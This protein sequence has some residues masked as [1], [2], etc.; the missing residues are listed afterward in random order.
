MNV[1]VRP[2][3]VAASVVALLVSLPLVALRAQPPARAGV[4]SSGRHPVRQGGPHGNA[5]ERPEVSRPPERRP[6][7]RVSLRLAVKAGSLDEAD[8]QQGLAHLIEH[9][10]FNGSAHFKPGEL[11]SYFESIGARLGPHV[12]AYT[13]FDETV[14]M[15]DLPTDKPEIVDEGAHRARRLRRRADARSRPKSTR[16]AASSSRNGAAASAPARASATSSSRSCSTTRAT[17]S[18]CRSASP[19]SSA[20]RRPARLRAFYDTWYR[21]ERMAV[22]AVGDIDAAAA[23]ADASRRA[24]G[25]SRRA[26]RRRRSPIGTV[27]LHQRAAR[28][29]RH[30]S[31]GHAVDRAARPQAPA[32]RRGSASPTT[33]A[34]WSSGSCEQMLNERFGE[35]ARKP[36]A[37][38]LG[39][40]AGSGALSRTVDDVLARRARSRTARS[41]TASP[42]SPSK[43]SA[44]AS[45]ASRRPSSTARRSGW[46][47][48]TSAPTTSAT[49]PRAARSRRSISNYFLEDEPSPGIDY[50]Y[51]LVQQLLPGD[52]A[53]TKCRRWRKA[54]LGDD[55]R[56]VLATSP[57]K[58][59]VRV[60][61][62]A[63][64]Q[65]ALDGGERVAGHAVER[66][67]V[68][69]R[70]DGE[71][72]D[73]GAVA[74][75]R[76][77]LDDSASP[78]VQFAN[79][80]E[81]WL[82]PTDFK[83][84]Q[85]LFT[86]YAPGGASLAPPAD[87]LEASL[88]TGYVEP[89]GRRRA[90]GARPAEAAGGQ[91][92]VRVAVHRAVDA[93]HLRIGARRR[94]SRRR[95]SCSTRRSPRRATTRRRSRC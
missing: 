39:A 67:G 29:R 73:A 77:M 33:A 5:A 16:S 1:R 51:A 65:A 95:C 52:H 88:A 22:V 63:D 9:M 35:L 41:T 12:N 21:P 47:R 17:P 71:Q 34:S 11:V 64:L 20:T 48:S 26:R 27:P 50:E 13:S 3:R 69:A 24:F 61:T 56:V 89:L 82:K 59:G 6:A 68:D 93:R 8:D 14:Y 55:S 62:E 78:I 10:A 83:N 92:R 81:A 46:R 4:Q 37:K 40:G 57:Q 44:C 80:V 87:Y 38:F 84:D 58:P 76:E 90:Q 36:D 31:G 94:S 42:R 45:S 74:S 70:A 15:L 30:R 72:A 28:Q 75:R 79:G 23:R 32:R 18:G 53:S 86:L 2:R 7:K 19:R 43:R 85:V 54:L 66:H 91:A 49:R 60:P 25:R